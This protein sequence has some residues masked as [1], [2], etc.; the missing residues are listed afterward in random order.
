MLL[1][2]NKRMVVQKE[3]LLE[4]P[5]LSKYHE[6]LAACLSLQQTKFECVNQPLWNPVGF[7]LCQ[8]LMTRDIAVVAEQCYVT[9]L[10]TKMVYNFITSKG[11]IAVAGNS[12]EMS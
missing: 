11:D 1:H 8:D 4:T 10:Y 9:L 12:N 6:I 2:P 5:G 7:K 3:I